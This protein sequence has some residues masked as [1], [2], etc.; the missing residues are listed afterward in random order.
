M[1]EGVGIPTH[2]WI[3]QRKGKAIF[4]KLD[5]SVANDWKAAIV[6]TVEE[7]DRVDV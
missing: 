4:V 5:F 6:K 1:G 3:V 7:Y 2:E